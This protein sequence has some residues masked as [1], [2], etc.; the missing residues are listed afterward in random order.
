MLLFSPLLLQL[1]LQT[2]PLGFITGAKKAYHADLEDT[3]CTTQKDPTDPRGNQD[4]SKEEEKNEV[5]DK[6]S[7]RWRRGK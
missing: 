7:L 6:P 5:L 4:H 1:K 3:K 2:L